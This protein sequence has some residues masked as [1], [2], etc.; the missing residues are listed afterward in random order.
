MILGFKRKP[1]L[2]KNH[3]VRGNLEMFPVLLG[4]ESQEGYQQISSRIENRHE[5]QQ[6]KTKHYFLSLST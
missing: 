6:N 5:E 2:W 3:V 4:L 1:N